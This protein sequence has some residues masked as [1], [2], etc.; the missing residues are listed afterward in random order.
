MVACLMN[1]FEFYH[2]RRPFVKSPNGNRNTEETDDKGAQ[3][4]KNRVAAKRFDSNAI[5]YFFMSGTPM[6]QAF[7]TFSPI[8]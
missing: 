6:F 2:I 8:A 7:P 5:F 1:Y 4:R 3:H